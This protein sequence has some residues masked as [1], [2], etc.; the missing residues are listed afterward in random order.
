LA[1]VA[2]ETAS[3]QE[4]VKS[5][6]PKRCLHNPPEARAF[7][8]AILYLSNPTRVAGLFFWWDVNRIAL[9]VL[10]QKTGGFL[11]GPSMTTT[12]TF[13]YRGYEI[14]A[15]RQWASWCASIYATR[16]DLPLMSRSTLRTLA[17]G[18]EA[19]VAEAIHS[20]DEVLARNDWLGN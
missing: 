16:A 19:A 4:A 5:A 17:P 6:R 8:L 20:I 14:V 11:R 9:A 2:G 15:Q 1:L 13:H 18:K 7:S 3:P 12:H 10:R